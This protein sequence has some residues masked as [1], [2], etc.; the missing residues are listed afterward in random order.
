MWSLPCSIS[1]RSSIFW[2]FKRYFISFEITTFPPTKIIFLNIEML[3]EI[4]DI[5]FIWIY[6]SLLEKLY[7]LLFEFEI[8]K[9]KKFVN[10]GLQDATWIYEFQKG[11][12]STDFLSLLPSTLFTLRI[13][14]LCNLSLIST[15]YV[16][17]C[18]ISLLLLY[19]Q[20]DTKK[21]GFKPNFLHMCM[22]KKHFISPKI[23]KF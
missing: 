2:I 15:T 16:Y 7:L 10:F 22:C 3:L 8:I 13:L 18:M 12:F 6:L 19:I 21:A 20:K 1:K 17:S 5:K 23:E 11:C 14:I 9:I 4:S